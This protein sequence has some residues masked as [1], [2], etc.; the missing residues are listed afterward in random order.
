M[1]VGQCVKRFVLAKPVLEKLGLGEGHAFSRRRFAY[2]TTFISLEI[3]LRETSD[4]PIYST[5]SFVCLNTGRDAGTSGVFL[6]MHIPERTGVP[7]HE[8][9]C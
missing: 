2:I 1:H 7:T 8:I 9:T 5:Q 3:P 4:T 6:S